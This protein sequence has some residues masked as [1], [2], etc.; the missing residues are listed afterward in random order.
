MLLAKRGTDEEHIVAPASCQPAIQLVSGRESS[1]AGE[2]DAGGNGTVRLPLLIRA[3]AA[4]KEPKRCPSQASP[5][6][7]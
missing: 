1:V 2:R 6:P 4:E 5:C 3:T 7:K